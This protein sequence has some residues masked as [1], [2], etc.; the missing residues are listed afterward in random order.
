MGTDA[1]AVPKV[2]KE[3]EISGSTLDL[4]LDLLLPEDG[5]E[6]EQ[7]EKPVPTSLA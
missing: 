2:L 1:A 3:C 4:G 5:A 6:E 7:L